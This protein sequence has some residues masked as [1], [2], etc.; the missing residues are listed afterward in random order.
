MRKGLCF[1]GK[2]IEEKLARE[3]REGSTREMN[4]LSSLQLTLLG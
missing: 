2:T 1:G 4:A 3:T